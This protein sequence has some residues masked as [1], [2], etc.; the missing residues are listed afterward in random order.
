MPSL[1]S[2]VT[3]AASVVSRADSWYN[4][5]TGFGSTKDRT[6]YGTFVDA[7]DI[8]D[9]E[10]EALFE[11]S[12]VARV[13]VSIF[14]EETMRQGVGI[15]GVSPEEAAAID[16]R[17]EELDLFAKIEQAMI[18]GR[19]YGGGMLVLGAVDGATNPDGTER[20]AQSELAVD[21]ITALPFVD[22]YDKR[23][24]E[25]HGFYSDPRHPKFGQ[26]A[27][28]EIRLPSGGSRYVHESRVV[29]F[30][31]ALTS[32][33]R[34]RAR[35]GWDQSI[36]QAGYTELGRF[37]GID[38]AAE[39]LVL[40]ASVGVLTL[41]G[42]IK[43]ITGVG[44][45]EMGIRSN[46]MDLM[47][48]SMRTM[49]LDAGDAAG[50]PPETYTRTDVTFTGLP[51]MM[52]RFAGRLAMVY[53]IPVPVLM[54]E[55]PAGLNATGEAP[56]RLFYD[57][58][59]TGAKRHTPNVARCLLVVARSLGI[60]ATPTCEW[61]SLW[62]LTPAEQDAHLAAESAR[63]V[64]YV[65]A[66]VLLPEEVTKMR[67]AGNPA[68]D[69]ELRDE[70]AAALPSG[71]APVLEEGD[72]PTGDERKTD[73]SVEHF[74]ARM[75]EKQIERCVHNR[76]NKCPQCGI[77]RVRDIDDA[78]GAFTVGWRAIAK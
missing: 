63:D 75:T 9:Y 72:G 11:D 1:S 23:D 50:A 33:A 20:T 59:R 39:N 2:I 45:E 67:F 3:A 55:A 18:W 58:V 56:V 42:V 65:G 12:G 48:N 78:T 77:E 47:R 5:I 64:A 28:W 73:E 26:V 32:K 44:R 27:I 51:D 6:A 31:G 10:L 76:P 22:V 60:A 53:R 15:G 38:A 70:P 34:K 43:A 71:E 54:G 35:N 49:L 52:D 19:L 17:C 8:S 61:P 29:L 24:I 16:K 41:R 74:A 13:I 36:L 25:R 69:L 37:L 40:D 62:Q 4:S 30:G 46:T 57:R 14:P 7:P 21:E 68:V 66:G